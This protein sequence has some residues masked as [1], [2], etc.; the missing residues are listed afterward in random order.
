MRRRIHSQQLRSIDLHRGGRG[1]DCEWG[2]RTLCNLFEQPDL[3]IIDL[4]AISVSYHSVRLVRDH[5]HCTQATRASFCIGHEG[6]RSRMRDAFQLYLYCKSSADVAVVYQFGIAIPRSFV[7]FTLH[8]EAV[9][10]SPIQA[11]YCR[12]C[13]RDGRVQLFQI[14]FNFHLLAS[15]P[16]PLSSN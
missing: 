12:D 1:G 13:P 16:H 15:I 9:L 2:F 5:A 10:Q 4:P 14:T 7:A 11:L 6:M 3:L 8:T